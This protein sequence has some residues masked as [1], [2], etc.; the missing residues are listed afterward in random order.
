MTGYN[1]A[2][3][4]ATWCGS[5]ATNITTATGWHQRYRF[6]SMRH[7]KLWSPWAL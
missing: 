4:M 3:M 6:L 7:V 5:R 1:T 2:A